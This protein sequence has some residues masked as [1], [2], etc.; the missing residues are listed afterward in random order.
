MAITRGSNFVAAHH[1]T[2]SK[3]GRRT[4]SL[5]E[6]CRGEPLPVPARKPYYGWWLEYVLIG[7]CIDYRLSQQ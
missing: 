7:P 4:L 6:D 1:R 3:Q 5:R 2:S